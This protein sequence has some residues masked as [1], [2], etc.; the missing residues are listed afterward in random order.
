MRSLSDYKYW[1]FHFDCLKAS[2]FRSEKLYW[3]VHLTPPG[4]SRFNISKQ[5]CRY[6]PSELDQ[7]FVS[8][9]FLNLQNNTAAHLEQRQR[10]SCKSQYRISS[11]SDLQNTNY[12][13]HFQTKWKKVVRAGIY[14]LGWDRP[15]WEEFGRWVIFVFIVICYQQ[16]PVM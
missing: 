2:D 6:R 8:E 14:G 7:F 4:R 15:G 11:I 10:N 1:K 9:L 3:G 12:F 13:N 5:S 16:I